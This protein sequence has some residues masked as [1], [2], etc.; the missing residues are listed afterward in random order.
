MEIREIN[1]G[2]I[3]EGTCKHPDGDTEFIELAFTD[4]K[5][6]LEHIAMHYRH[7]DYIDIKYSDKYKD[8]VLGE[9]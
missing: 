8:E 6:L 4:M 3:V 1:N 7:N 9:G 5:E 2:W